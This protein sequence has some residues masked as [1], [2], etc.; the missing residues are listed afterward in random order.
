LTRDSLRRSPGPARR[1]AGANTLVTNAKNKLT[2]ELKIKARAVSRGI[3][4]GKV[5]SLYGKKRQ[6]YRIELKDSQLEREMRRLRA[7]FRLAKRQLRKLSH[8]QPKSISETQANIF[9]AHLMILN[10][11]GFVGK[12]ETII[13]DE[14]VNAEWAV[15]SVTERYLSIYKDI[16]D[17]Y[18]RERR[19]DF[20]D[21]SERLLS[22]LGGERNNFRLDRDAIIVASEVKPSTL[23][24]LSQSEPKA[25]IA[26]SGGWT[27]HTF[28]LA[29]EL[30]LPAVTGIKGVL[31]RIKTGETAIVDGYQG[32]VYINPSETTIHQ[33]EREAARFQKMTDEY[34]SSSRGELKTLDGR[35]ITIRANLDLPQG[36]PKAKRIGATGIGLFRSEFLF[37]QYQTLPTE[38]QQ[39]DAYRKIAELAGDEGVRIR[40]FDISLEQLNDQ[41]NIQEKNPSLGLRAIRLSISHEKMFRTQIRALLRASY[42]RNLDLVLPMVSDIWEIRLARSIIADE[43]TKLEARKIKYGNPRIGAMIEVPSAVLM[44]DEIAREVDFLSVGTNDLVQYLLA[45]DRDNELAADW[46][47]SLHPAVL[48][49]LKRILSASEST[50]TPAIICGEMAGSH[51]YATILVGLGATELSMHVNAMPRVRH[52]ISNIAYEEAQAIVKTLE[53]CRTAD[54]VEAEVRAHLLSKWAHLFPA[55]I[56]PPSKWKTRVQEG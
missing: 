25:I 55:T 42:E 16:Q 43:R 2:N 39:F 49:S 40:T 26:E 21:V 29:R 8:R 23:V 47:R 56:L 4:I 37:N 30:G 5:V 34:L 1:K 38:K 11:I 20:Q 54:E 19:I 53:N 10:D 3:A 12:I 44:I 28:I 14:K 52:I 6:F 15:K 46:F 31:R 9:E 33:Y 36:Y 22:A 50:G 27:S 7:A 13:R 18:L 51:V 48:R 17:E 24:E 35:V 45:V 32:Q 41:T